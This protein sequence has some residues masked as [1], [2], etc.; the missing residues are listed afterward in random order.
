MTSRR[1]QQSPLGALRPAECAPRQQ[2]HAPVGHATG[3]QYADA[4]PHAVR[5]ADRPR[6]RSHASH[7]TPD[8]RRRYVTSSH[9]RPVTQVRDVITRQ[10]SDVTCWEYTLHYMHR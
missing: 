5:S 9:G 3:E 10:T 1:Y 6:Y 8:K 4:G 7:N 2:L